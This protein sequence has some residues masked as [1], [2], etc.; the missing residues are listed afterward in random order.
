MSKDGKWSCKMCGW[1]NPEN[2]KRCLSCKK[3][4]PREKKAKLPRTD[5][6]SQCILLAMDTASVTGWSI[7]VCGMLE[8]HG[9]HKLYTDDGLR[10]TQLVCE[11][12]TQLQE[13][14]S[15]P[16]VVV[17]ERS[18]GGH[19]GMGRTTAFGY[20]LHA[21]RSI[22]VHLK[23]FIEVYPSEWRAVALP[24]GSVG[25]V[26]DEVRAIEMEA[27]QALVNG[28]SLGADEAPAIMI[29]VW[30]MHSGEVARVLK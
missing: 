3:P 15:L 21:L 6:P 16:I 2:G 14:T 22:G 29:G 27:A 20:W 11:K 23:R 5:E 26:R 17:S 1:S 12:L 30:G 10:A 24:P 7:R 9:Q 18:W 19:M 28:A 4:R 25:K 13:M 8:S